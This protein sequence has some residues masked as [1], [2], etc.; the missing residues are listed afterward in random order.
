MQDEALEG[1]DAGVN[2]YLGGERGEIDAG[3]QSVRRK[4]FAPQPLDRRAQRERPSHVEEGCRARL[5]SPRSAESLGEHVECTVNDGAEDGCRV[6]RLGIAA[7]HM[8][9]AAVLKPP[10]AR[11][12][13]D[14]TERAVAEMLWQGRRLR[15]L[16]LKDG[17]QALCPSS[18]GPLPSA[19][20]CR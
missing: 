11:A 16:Q 12:C 5:R 20:L 19:Q 9:I 14:L 10:T 13:F 7:L 8:A 17:M 3:V 2:R 1:S 6:H 4:P 15:R 18:L